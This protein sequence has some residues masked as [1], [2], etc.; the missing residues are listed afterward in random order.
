MLGNKATLLAMMLKAKV[1]LRVKRG[2]LVERNYIITGIKISF[3]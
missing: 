1:S 3:L 2:N